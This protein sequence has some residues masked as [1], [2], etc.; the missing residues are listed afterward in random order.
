MEAID[1]FV[2][3]V[4]NT[5]DMDQYRGVAGWLLFVAIAGIIVQAVMV[6]TCALYYGEVIASQLVGVVFR[7]VVSFNKYINHII[8]AIHMS[9]GQLI[10]MQW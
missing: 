4:D 3:N 5:E 1:V 10:S 7:I 9:R 8:V 2:S 6:I